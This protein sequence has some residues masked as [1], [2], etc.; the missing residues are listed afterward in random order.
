MYDKEKH[1]NVCLPIRA[2]QAL[3]TWQAVGFTSDN[4]VF[5]QVK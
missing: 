3:D 2:L 4:V 5:E 1:T